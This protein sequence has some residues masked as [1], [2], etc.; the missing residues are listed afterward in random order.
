MIK[1]SRLISKLALVLSFILAT[2]LGVPRSASAQ[3]STQIEF[4]GQITAISA[5]TI[6]VRGISVDISSAEVQG[7]LAVGSWVKVEG[8]LTTV[9]TVAAR[10]VKV[11]PATMTPVGDEVELRGTITALASTT[12]TVDGLIVDISNAEI[13]VTL[14]IGLRVKVEG[15]F[16]TAGV[17]I[18][19]QVNALLPNDDQDNS[20][21]GEVEFRGTITAVNGA[22]LTV[23][24]LSVDTSNAE[25]KGT[26]AVGKQVKV[27]GQLVSSKSV[28]A[29]EVEVISSIRD[30]RGEDDSSDD[31]GDDRGDDNSGGGSGRGGDD[32]R[33]GD[34]RGGDRGGGR[35]GD[36]GGSGRGDD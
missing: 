3:S 21:V 28:K 12:I 6:T 2:A 27:E 26:L 1:Q 19:R 36:D 23:N 5:N 33:G 14:A 13:N 16:G 15:Q 29:R 20:S 25:I 32:D 17:L 31:Q 18:A 24:G 10:E 9:T 11:I 8:T 22:I 34:D 7:Q 35:G 4:R 30:R